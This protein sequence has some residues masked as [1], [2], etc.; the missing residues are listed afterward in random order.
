ML[1]ACPCVTYVII[2]FNIIVFK[3]GPKE[4][5]KKCFFTCKGFLLPRVSKT[6]VLT[7]NKT[8]LNVSWLEVPAICKIFHFCDAFYKISAIIRFNIFTITSFNRWLVLEGQKCTFSNTF[9]WD[10]TGT[11]VFCLSL[12]FC[13]IHLT[14]RTLFPLCRTWLLLDRNITV[15]KLTFT[16]LKH[17]SLKCFP[18]INRCGDWLIILTIV[19]LS[20][21]IFSSTCF[22]S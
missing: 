17:Y 3:P 19:C 1:I 21:N 4:S 20:L 12:H 15:H 9:N 14:T 10:L 6:H 13:W 2:A 22:T 8:F 7:I 11:K 5:V 16:I 18:V